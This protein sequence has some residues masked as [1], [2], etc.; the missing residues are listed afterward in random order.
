MLPFYNVLE[1]AV[2]EV[3]SSQETQIEYD[4]HYLKNDKVEHVPLYHLLNDIF[5]SSFYIIFFNLHDHFLKV[6]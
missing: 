6:I 3:F 4:F 5:F 2:E 1:D